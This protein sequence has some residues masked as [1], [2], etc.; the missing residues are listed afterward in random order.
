ML[1][2]V[3]LFDRFRE[4]PRGSM[5]GIFAIACVPRISGVG[6]A[7]GRTDAFFAVLDSIAVQLRRLRTDE[8]GAVS[9]MMGILL[10]AMA[11]FLALG[12]E[13]S[14]WYLITRGMQNAADAATI[15]AAFNNSAKYD[16]EARAVAAQ[17]GF[18]NGANNVNVAVTNTAAC[19]G[20]GKNCYSVSISGFTPLLL[21]QLVGFQGN[22]NINGALQKQLGASAVATPSGSPLCLLALATSGAPQGIR[23]N[24][25]PFAN[26]QGCSSLSNTAAQCNGHNLGLD[27]S[28]AVGS[29]NGCGNKQTPIP[30]PIPDPFFSQINGNIKA[31]SVNNPCGTNAPQI[32]AKKSDPPLPLSNFLSGSYNLSGNVFY[33]GDQQLNGNVTINTPGGSAVMIIVNGQLDL[34]GYQFKTASGAAL[35]IVFTGDPTN[36]TYTHAPT[37]SGH[38]GVLDITPPT[39]GPWAGMAIVQDPNLMTGVDISS[40]GNSPTWNIT[41][42]IYTP[43][44]TI[45][46]KGAIDK[47]TNGQRCVV[48]V[49][50]NFQISGTGGILKT[51]VQNCAAAGLTQPKSPGGAVLVQ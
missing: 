14:N 3:R 20:G 23:T 21:S 25:A 43:H 15:A 28:Y 5:A 37:D 38:G 27:V 22:G 31:L 17:Y 44:A 4:G 12:F 7:T 19:P 11:G 2:F 32:P 40:A 47:S 50:D 33:C 51:N 16:V 18:V 42:L 36:P 49:A 8:R 9:A 24:G 29:N 30:T 26:M 13:V 48:M 1:T 10:V 46:L 41:G 6:A 35:T 45:T 39:T 34:A